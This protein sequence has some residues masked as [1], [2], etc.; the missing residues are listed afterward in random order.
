MRRYRTLVGGLLFAALMAVIFTGQVRGA[1]TII[2]AG[3]QHS[4]EEAA[5]GDSLTADLVETLPG[6]VMPV[7]DMA[8]DWGYAEEYECYRPTWGRFMD[9]TRAV[10]GN[11][12]WGN[13]IQKENGAAAF[14]E[15]FAGTIG[16]RWHP[17]YYSFDHGMWKV[18][19]LD[20]SCDTLSTVVCADQLRWLKG[21]LRREPTK[22]VAAFYHQPTWSSMQYGSLASSEGIFRTLYRFGADLVVSAHRHGYE[23]FAPMGPDGPSRTGPRAFVVGT[24]GTPRWHKWRRELPG[25]EVRLREWGVLNLTLRWDR[26]DWQFIGVDGTIRDAGTDRCFPRTN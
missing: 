18:Y 25:T 9:R 5:D 4:C 2:A 13:G 10:V 14:R 8:T 23:R 15:F 21:K 6:I 26:F 7:G 17:T 11:H 20:A 12:D 22:C 1:A 16:P 19:V 24:G 3:D